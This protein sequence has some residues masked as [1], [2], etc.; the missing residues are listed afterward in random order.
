MQ[1]AQKFFENFMKSA[2]KE[3]SGDFPTLFLFCYGNYFHAL[4]YW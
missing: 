2:Q 3:K 1:I 4:F